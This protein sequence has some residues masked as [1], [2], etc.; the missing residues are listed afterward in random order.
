LISLNTA[1]A[2][3]TISTEVSSLQSSLNDLQ[4][5]SAFPRITEGIARL[6]SSLKKLMEL[7]ESARSEGYHF[8]PDLEQ[9]AYHSMSQ[10]EAVRPQLASNVQQQ[11]MGLQ[12]QILAINP[13]VQ[14][15][16]RVLAVPSAATPQI[17]NAQNQVNCLL[18]Q[19][20]TIESSL[21]SSYSEIETQVSSASQRLTRIHWAMD[22]LSEAK[23]KLQ[24]GE[25]LVMAVPNRWDQ[26]GKDDPEGI[27]YLTNKRLVF[28]RKEKVA[29]KKVLF[30]TTASELVHEV[31]IDQ[32]LG[33]VRS[34][35]PENR[36]LFG[37][38]D[39]LLVEFADQKLGSV[40]FHIDGQDCKEWASLI[41]RA[42]SGQIEAERVNASAGIS[43]SDLT[44]PINPADVMAIQSEVNS[45]QDE[46]MLKASKEE[47]SALENEVRSL[48]RKLAGVRGRGYEVERGLEADISILAAQW[49]RIKQNAE[50][51]LEHQA[52]LL[53]EQMRSIRDSLSHLAGMSGNLAAA[54]PVYMQLKSSI[55]SA[56]AQADAARST[57]LAQFD[58][59]A[60]EVSGLSAHL[61]W[62]NWMLDAVDTA[63][64][65]LLATECG[66]AAVEAVF[67]PP[68]CEPENGILFLTDQRLLWEDRVDAYELKVNVPLQEVLDIQKEV[69]ESDGRESINFN[70]G[71]QGPVPRAHFQLALAVADD[72]LKMVGRAR[73]GGYAMDRAE[74]LSEEE[75]D[76][77][78][79]APQQ[80]SNCGAAFTAPLLRGQ[81]EIRCE[82]CGLVTRL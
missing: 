56:E 50:T 38:Q 68:N 4:E 53:S 34:V 8:Q 31:Q 21:E 37:H 12:N 70:L 62:V 45:L 28:E 43:M 1:A 30:I 60:D 18:E 22:Q 52:S 72:W 10:W 42:C 20:S 49:D 48:E 23:F 36:G 3:A 40:A 55:A 71:P 82:Y 26:E 81:T 11:A 16:N 51:T 74:S 41:E 44:R 39:F 47:L 79:N 14:S 63:S 78:R 13:L 66:I 2:D 35:Q 25:E 7:L 15:V 76:R 69:N 9:V 33:N 65:R 54:R 5:R 75:L 6:D 27:L 58:L 80:C 17:R 57:V 67:Q 19:I 73:S 46:M 64:F 61:D 77:V 29:T 24:N 59:Y 32:P